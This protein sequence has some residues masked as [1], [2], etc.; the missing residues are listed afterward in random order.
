MLLTSNKSA[1]SVAVLMEPTV[2]RKI[3]TLMHWPP[4]LAVRAPPSVVQKAWIGLHWQMKHIIHADVKAMTKTPQ[5]IR[6][7]RNWTIG[8]I[9]YWKKILSNKMIG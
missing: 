8:K 7:R 6:M 4:S 1:K 3:S 9:R 5:Y 2:S